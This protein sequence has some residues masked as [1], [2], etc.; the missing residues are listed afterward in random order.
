MS[1]KRGMVELIDYDEN[2]Q[3]EYKKE[4]KILKDVLGEKIKEI[5]HIG[6]TSILGLKAKPI[7]DIL[8][9]IN[10]LDE[11]QEIEKELSSYGYENRGHQGVEDR[12][13]LRKVLKKQEAT[14]FIL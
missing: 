6:S 13:F 12:Y 11:I 9:V 4:E 3:E 8:V 2:W 5:H 14:I 1:L 10:D 7:I